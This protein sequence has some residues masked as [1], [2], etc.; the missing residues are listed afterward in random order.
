MQPLPNL[1]ARR[2]VLGVTGGIAAYKAAD[3]VRRLKECGADVQVVMT[4]SAKKFVTPL[5]FQAV[6]GREVRS[7]LFDP[8]HEAAMGHIELARW[9]D[10]ILVAPASANFLARLAQGAADDLLT[11]LCLATDKPVL[12]APS[13]NRLMWAN[14]AT[15]ANVALLAQRGVRLLGPGAGSQA[16]G[17]VGDGRM[18]E[19]LQIRDAVADLLSNGPLKN[20]RAV[21]TAGP[22]REALDPVRF[23]TNRSS[24]KMG[25]AVASA[26][27]QLGA[28]VTLVSGPT[29]LAA[30]AGV[31][32]VEVESAAQ[33][34]EAALAAARQAQIFV[35]TAAVADYRAAAPAPEKIKKK[36]ERLALDLVKTDDILSA[37]R[38][39]HPKLFMVGFAAETEKLEEHARAKLESKKL[40]LVA[41]NWV[42]NG[43]AFDRDDNALTVLWRGGAQELAQ[44]PKAEL[45]RQ[46]AVLI[47]GR[48]ARS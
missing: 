38:A 32:R 43:R 40:D 15:Q 39:R 21:V 31:E 23:I 34:L 28:Q 47:A 10:L 48:L 42:G 26:L 3:L 35:G 33:M 8:A 20:L 16:C 45:A 37:V 19:P 24:G 44:A 41:A 25:Y 46:L 17:E 29:G 12:A 36:S 2:I 27:A 14:A 1:A 6:S 18:W 11:T 7:T 22:T 13:M 30:P 4:A 5:T 9:P